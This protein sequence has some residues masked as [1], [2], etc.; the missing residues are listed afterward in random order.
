MWWELQQRGA[1]NARREEREEEGEGQGGKR[2]DRA[3]FLPTPE[4]KG[5][6][7]GQEGKGENMNEH[8]QMEKETYEERVFDTTYYVP[9]L[10]LFVKFP[11]SNFFPF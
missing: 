8:R 9:G 10:V 4:E 6:T 3:S 5:N 7:P 2:R 1:L 11:D